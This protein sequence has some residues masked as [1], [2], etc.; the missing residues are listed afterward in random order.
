MSTYAIIAGTIAGN[1]G[2]EAMLEATVGRLREADQDARIILYSYMPDADAKVLTDSSITIRSCTPKKLVLVHFPFALLVGFF[3]LLR[4]NASGLTPATVR[5]LARADA[6]VDLAGVSFIDGREKFL[7][8]NILTIWPAM[9]MGVPVFKLSQ[10]VGPFQNRFNR[11]A[12][13]LLNRCA[14]L[15]PRGA[16]TQSHVKELG[17]AYHVVFPAPDTAFAFRAEDSLSSEGAE[18]VARLR[19]LI[20]EDRRESVVGI[21]PSSVIASR[22]ADEG[23]D[24]IGYLAEVVRTMISDGHTVLLFPNATRAAAGDELRNNDLPVIRDVVA[25]AGLS[26]DDGLHAVEG[27]VC[28]AELR[29]L[30]RTCDIVGVSRF[31]AMVGALAEGVPVAV[32]GWSHKYAEV[33]ESFGLEKWS[34]DYSV[35]DPQTYIGLLRDLMAQREEIA[36]VIEECLPRIV[37]QSTSQFAQVVRRVGESP[38]SRRQG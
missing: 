7:P 16:T 29:R 13:G 35:H 6:L 10:A 33:M 9:A 30:V 15:V 22:A 17:V 3:R 24:Y 37:M 20:E 12:A 2:A 28:A 38:G 4:I 18:E 23:W 36:A 25:K 34:F 8:F 31:H 27:D 26:A 1:R 11:W 21:C 32:M 5:D 14:M 19:A